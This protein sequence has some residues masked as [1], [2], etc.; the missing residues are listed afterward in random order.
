MLISR[1]CARHRHGG[2]EGGGDGSGLRGCIGQTRSTSRANIGRA[3]DVNSGGG[4]GDSEVGIMAV[5]IVA[6][7]AVVVVVVAAAA[8]AAAPAGKNLVDSKPAVRD[9]VVEPVRRHSTAA[10]LH[11][12]HAACISIEHDL[13]AAEIEP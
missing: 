2:R 6:V 1:D 7:V 4:G 11:V 13:V 9:L 10:T 3:R 8:A 12:A 5:G